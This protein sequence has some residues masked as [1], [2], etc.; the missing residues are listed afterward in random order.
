MN[1]GLTLRW[2]YSALQFNG[3]SYAYFPSQHLNNMQSFT[4]EATILTT[5]TTGTILDQGTGGT[6]MIFNL[7]IVNGYLQFTGINHEKKYLHLV[8][9]V[10]LSLNEWH[11]VACTFDSAGKQL[12]LY[13]DGV[14]VASMAVT[15]TPYPSLPLRTLIGVTVSARDGHYE[16]YFNGQI[17]RIAIWKSARN[18][19]EAIEDALALTYP[20]QKNTDLVFWAD[21]TEMP[22]DDRSGNLTP[23]EYS[24][25]PPNYLYSVPSVKVTETGV[26]DCGVSP[27]Y[28]FDGN[29]PYTIEGWFNPSATT[30]YTVM[31]AF[32]QHL[33]WQYFIQYDK[34]NSRIIAKRNTDGEAIVSNDQIIED[35]FYHFAVTY[36]GVSNMMS[37]YING[38]LQTS[39]Y[40]PGKAASLDNGKL[41]I[42]GSGYT[43]YF[44]QIRLWN[45]C[46]EQ[47]EIRQWMLNDVVTDPRLVANFDFTVTPPAD[48]MGHPVQLLDG[49]ANALATTV[50]T[51]DQRKAQLGISM[52]I[53]SSYF[54]E[55]EEK[56]LPYPPGVKTAAQP[57]LFSQEHKE[58]TYAGLVSL[59]KL[60]G[61]KQHDFNETFEKA[62]ALAEK[63]FSGNAALQKV[64]TRT[65]ENGRTKIIYHGLRGDVLFY[66]RPVG[67][68][69]DC[70]IWWITFTFTM[71]VSFFGIFLPLPIFSPFNQVPTKIFNMI[72]KNAKLIAKITALVGTTISVASALDV[73]TA[74]HREKILWPILKFAF[75]AAGWFGLAAL[76]ARII[77][78]VTGTVAAEILGK[79]IVW[80]AQ[81]TKLS[82]EYHGACPQTAEKTA[83]QT[84]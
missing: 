16:N 41:S 1:L 20:N 62:Y 45:E 38:N 26:I 77:T 21:F 27:A 56:P 79:F 28:N 13:Q 55:K 46:L 43:G 71:T 81:L 42:G 74:I 59:F 23:I 50:I 10:E 2:G 36:N 72:V 47:A 29:K 80:A 40:F 22:T 68:V 44:Q 82:L 3:N 34:E 30:Q 49:T 17:S 37:L 32:E 54:N 7:T 6:G 75:I 18:I 48:S 76:L 14:L 33:Q 24:T 69:S 84:A 15:G 51:L 63:E 73:I 65:D 31:L 19:F 9:P 12:S 25:E 53:N 8:S 61:K 5:T 66:D 78:L 58:K 64:V 52:P 35:R 83:A 70:T 39:E 60:E 57:E 11:Q 4:L 67:E